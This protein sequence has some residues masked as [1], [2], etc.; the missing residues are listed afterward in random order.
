DPAR[1]PPSLA[2]RAHGDPK[3][4]TDPATDHELGRFQMM[5]APLRRSRRLSAHPSLAFLRSAGTY[6]PCAV[7]GALLLA[8][9]YAHATIGACDTGFAV[10]I[11]A[12]A[13]T[14]GPTGYLS[15][16]AALAKINDGTHQGVINVEICANSAE[17]T[18]PA[19]LNSSGA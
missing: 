4:V 10:E 7:I 9:P 5:H 13:G 12:T 2:L 19:T 6:L 8:A 15:L 16:G 17:G 1:K 14:T 3:T 18:T 11:E